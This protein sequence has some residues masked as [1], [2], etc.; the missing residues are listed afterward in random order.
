MKQTILLLLTVGLAAAVVVADDEPRPTALPDQAARVV[1]DGAW[2]WFA[3]P[4]ALR[5]GDNT[6]VGYV[7]SGGDIGVTA[8][9][10]QTRQLAHATLHPRLQSDDHAN[11][12]L[13]RLADG[14]LMAFYSG[15]NSRDMFHRTTSKP[16]DISAWDDEKKLPD[17]TGRG[18]GYT[19]PNPV[20]LTEEKNRI[21]L[22]W[23]GIGWNPTYA[24]SDD[25][26]ATWSESRHLIKAANRPYVKVASDGKSTIH[27]A[28]TDGHPHQFPH[29]NIYY[30]AMRG[31]QFYNA[32]GEKVGSADSLPLALGAGDTVYDA[33]ATDGGRGW[34]W[35]IAL[36]KEG[37]PVLVFATI[38][39]KEN[40]RYHYARHDGK[41]WQVHP[42][43][44]AGV[45]IDG[46]A[47]WCYSGGIVLDHKDPSV[48][49]LSRVVE[50][51]HEIER[52]QTPDGGRS[53]KTQT[54][55]SASQAKNVRPVVVR[56]HE[57]EMVVLWMRGRY[58][59]YTRYQT[60]L[61]AWP[62]TAPVKDAPAEKKE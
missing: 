46:P 2:C 45:Y 9:N 8:F 35:D 58:D 6:F 49:F 52:R 54:I 51:Q 41:G 32:A 7:S 40:H 36:D 60:E 30:V 37:R 28:Y 42:I 62:M 61:L 11:P 38:A 3:D 4:R 15:H 5:A 50:G 34:I 39:D 19:Y 12:A 18:R 47:E 56:N 33:K 1:E 44:D 17:A 53:W 59:F 20:R 22:F 43:T 55:T 13:L 26:G 25:A 24:T 23:R 48:V 14:R 57:K 31:G 29:N 16:D 10:H 27:V 21:Y